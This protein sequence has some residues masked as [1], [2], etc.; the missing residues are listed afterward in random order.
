MKV[1]FSDLIKAILSNMK[2]HNFNC[3]KVEA[4]SDTLE[5]LV[6]RLDIWH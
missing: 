5:A 6:K 4:V 2:A 1:N 3:E